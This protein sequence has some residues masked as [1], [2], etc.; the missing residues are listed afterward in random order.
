[1]E[2]LYGR[3]EFAPDI[4]TEKSKSLQQTEMPAFSIVDNLVEEEV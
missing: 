1:M 3:A 2:D 4:I